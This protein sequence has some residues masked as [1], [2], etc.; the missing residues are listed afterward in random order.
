MKATIKGRIQ[1]VEPRYETLLIGDDDIDIAEWII[2]NLPEKFSMME[3]PTEH[4][5]RITLEVI[6]SA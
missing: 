6:E 1:T 2:K 5:Y 4:T 3:H